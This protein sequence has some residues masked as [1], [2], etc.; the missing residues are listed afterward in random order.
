VPY[1]AE[2]LLYYNPEGG[3]FFHFDP[4]CPTLSER[5]WPNVQSASMADLIQPHYAALRPCALCV[6][7]GTIAPEAQ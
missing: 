7:N 3:Q 5:F 4:H 2:D 1:S 6:L